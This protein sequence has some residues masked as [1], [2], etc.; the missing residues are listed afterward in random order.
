MELG[1]HTE[2][3]Q[4]QFVMPILLS[5]L[6]PMSIQN[7]FKENSERDCSS[8]FLLGNEITISGNV[9]AFFI[10]R[11]I[12]V[13]KYLISHGIWPSFQVALSN[14]QQRPTGSLGLGAEQKA[15]ELSFE[16][17]GS[18][19]ILTPFLIWQCGTWHFT[20]GQMMRYGCSAVPYSSCHR[21]IA[22]SREKTL[23]TKLVC[24]EML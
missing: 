5:R 8:L 24:F 7:P 10:T 21:V 14:G 23:V 12:G 13:K 17:R 16:D 2:R 15:S 9:A 4:R 1:Q 22:S 11:M 3:V 20:R 19:G 18:V 6:E